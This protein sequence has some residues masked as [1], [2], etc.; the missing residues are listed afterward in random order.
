MTLPK[1]RAWCAYF[2]V[3][4]LIALE[5]ENLCKALREN[6]DKKVVEILEKEF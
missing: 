3:D 2:T 1:F 4:P 5:N 6:D